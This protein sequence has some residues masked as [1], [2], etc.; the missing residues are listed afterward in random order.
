MP[1]NAWMPRQTQM[2][3]MSFCSEPAGMVRNRPMS[4]SPMMKL[5]PSMVAEPKACS[6]SAKGQPQDSL[7]QM[8]TDVDSSNSNM[9]DLLVNQ[10][11][12]GSTSL[13]R[14]YIDT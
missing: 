2:I 10:R 8:A 7:T 1:L 4:L 3:G 12:V 14:Q 9:R 11:L 5:K 6:V 13:F